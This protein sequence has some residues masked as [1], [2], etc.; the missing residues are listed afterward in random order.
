M[1]Y[2]V[3]VPLTTDAHALH[4]VGLGDIAS[5]AMSTPVDVGPDGR[6]GMLFGW[7]KEFRPPL[8][9]V[10]PTEQDWLPAN[11]G[12]L[13]QIGIWKN[14]PP[15]PADLLKPR[16]YGGKI[17]GLGDGYE[18]TVPSCADLPHAW[19]WDE[20]SG[21]PRLRARQEFRP[22]IAEAVAM[23]ERFNS[24]DPERGVEPHEAVEFA[25]RALSI[26]YRLT[27]E[28]ASYLELF[29]SGNKGTLRACF[30]LC[31]GAGEEA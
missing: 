26:N 2:L 4:A 17:V 30:E 29:T 10:R 27:H 11:A 23:E 15:T 3:F 31:V 24:N 22:L 1:H 19:I 9:A 5:G 28:V 12:G 20:V 18:W 25:F 13:Y 21:R 7:Q 16:N 8:L 6:P 14:D